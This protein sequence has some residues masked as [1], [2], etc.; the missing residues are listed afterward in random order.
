VT[1]V[2]IHYDLERRLADSDAESVAN[3]HS[4]YGIFR[5]RVAPDLN[6]VDVEYDASRLSEKD[7]EGVLIRFGIPI[8]RKWSV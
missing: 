4:W 2:D 3:V 5:V 8:Q 1:K 7:V 6:S